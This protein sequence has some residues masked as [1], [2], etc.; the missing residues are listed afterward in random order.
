M[1]DRDASERLDHPNRF[2][3]GVMHLSGFY[4]CHAR[5]VAVVVVLISGCLDSNLPTVTHESPAEEV[6]V[7]RARL[8][9]EANVRAQHVACKSVPEPSSTGVD[10]D[11]IVG[12]PYAGMASSGVS[13]SSG[14]QLFVFNATVQN[15]MDMALATANG[16]T[17]DPGGVRVF[18]V[19]APTVTSGSGTISVVNETGTATFT[20]AGQD[21]FQYG[22]A[23]GGINQNEL[24]ADG[25]LSPGEIWRHKPE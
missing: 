10:A 5:A 11:I 8:L 22:G 7:A 19:A 6:P 21:Y 2:S 13:Y 20:A 25:I 15:L 12:T 18:L 1:F 24:G 23:I 9:C 3:K 17:R 14:T 16:T 4:R